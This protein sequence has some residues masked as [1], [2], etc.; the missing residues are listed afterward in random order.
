MA[1]S[2]F[3]RCQAIVQ[4][5]TYVSIFISLSVSNDLVLARHRLNILR[6]IIQ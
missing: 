3:N 1:A 6:I 2:Q 4:M 5:Y